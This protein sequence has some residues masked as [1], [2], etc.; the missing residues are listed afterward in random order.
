MAQPETRLAFLREQMRDCHLCGNDCGVNRNAGEVSI[1]GA[2]KLA[3]VSHVEVHMGE[4]PP[5]SGERGCGNIFF[6]HCS[7]SCVYCQNW[8]ISNEV[9]E[10]APLKMGPDSLA[11]EMV[12][13][14]EAGVQTLGLVAPTSHLPTVVP[15]LM[16]A[17]LSGLHLPVVYNTSGFETVG[18]LRQLDGLVDVYLPDMKYG[19]DDAARVYSGVTGYVGTNRNA[20]TEMYRQV[21]ELVVDTDG[22]ARRGLIIRHLVLP[23]GAADTVDVLNW[24]ATRLSRDVHVSLMSQYRPAYQV[25]KGLFPELNRPI[26]EEEY[27]FHLAVAEELGF[28]NVFVQDMDSKDVLNPDFTSENPFG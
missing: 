23:G 20:V 21:G 18:A 9:D 28:T 14:Q 11:M 4:E 13:L 25:A 8:Q 7:L 26:T 27:K 22:I 3:E 5:V 15:A 16:R 19:S 17:R 24:I 2:D 1:C 6:H 12:R 10:V